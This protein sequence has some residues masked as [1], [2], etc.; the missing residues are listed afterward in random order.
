MEPESSPP[1]PPD[2]RAKGWRFEID[3]EKIEQSDTWTLA[4]PEVR[5]W[6]LMLWM[7]SW[8]QTPCGSLDNSDAL[9]A[10]RIGMSAKLFSKHRDILMRGW[11]RASDGRLY[12]D[13]ITNRVLAMLEKRA[14]DARR[15]ANRRA[16]PQESQKTNSRVTD[17]SRVTPSGLHSEFDTKHQAPVIPEPE[18]SKAIPTSSGADAPTPPIAD[19]PLG[20]EKELPDLIFGEGLKFLIDRGASEKNARSVLA[21]VKSKHGDMGAWLMIEQAMR[22]EVT[23]PMSWLMARTVVRKVTTDRKLSLA[24]QSARDV[25]ASGELSNAQ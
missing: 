25:R 17:V 7:T 5:P 14:K 21:M 8:K 19:L 12:H 13:T 15:T 20:S 1:Y 18:K 6:L 24:E 22:E 10:A 2:T 16:T 11:K 23:E 9:I 4:P 3:Y